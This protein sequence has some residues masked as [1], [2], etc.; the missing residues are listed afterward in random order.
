[1]NLSNSESHH[2]RHNRW[3]HRLHRLSDHRMTRLSH[4][5]A[6]HHHNRNSGTHADGMMVYKAI[7]R[8]RKLTQRKLS[9]SHCT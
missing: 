2:H 9:E 3:D 5:D 7:S 1:M 4:Y 8:Y 6:S